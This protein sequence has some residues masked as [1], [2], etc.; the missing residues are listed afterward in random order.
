MNAR[1]IARFMCCM[2]VGISFAGTVSALD[3]S[4][5]GGGCKGTSD[6]K[7]RCL[8]KGKCENDGSGTCESGCSCNSGGVPRSACACS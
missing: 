8:A 4:G 7:A 3:C 1:L 5:C 6:R 2:L